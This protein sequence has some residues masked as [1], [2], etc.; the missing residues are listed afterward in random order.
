MFTILAA[1]CA[2]EV[3][4]QRAVLAVYFVPVLGAGGTLEKERRGPTLLG[5]E[6]G[7]EP[8]VIDLGAARNTQ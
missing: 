2:R 1:D 3:L 8:R 5:P 4:D 7:Q 6:A